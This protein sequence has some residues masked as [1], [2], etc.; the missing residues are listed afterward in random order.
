MTIDNEGTAP[1]QRAA[2]A[3]YWQLRTRLE[4]V[5]FVAWALI[6]LVPTAAHLAVALLRHM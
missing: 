4:I 6:V 3:G 2:Q 5:R 1:E